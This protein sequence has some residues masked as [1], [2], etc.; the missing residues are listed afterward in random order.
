MYRKMNENTLIGENVRVEKNSLYN[1]VSLHIDINNVNSVV[2]TYSQIQRP[3]TPD[4]CI[5]CFDV[6]G[7]LVEGSTLLMPTCGCKYLV[8]KRCLL[9]W[10]YKKEGEPACI[11]CNSKCQI[12]ETVMIQE[13]IERREREAEVEIADHNIE[14]AEQRISR[15]CKTFALLIIFLTVCWILIISFT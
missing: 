9:D 1:P 8:H 15:L 14:S 5:I 10:M 4:S 6:C 2:S 11:T 12:Q 13:I 7:D 3:P